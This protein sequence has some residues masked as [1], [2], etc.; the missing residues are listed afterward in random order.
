MT[1]G[2]FFCIKGFDRELDFETRS[3]KFILNMWVL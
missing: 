1:G 2:R 3:G